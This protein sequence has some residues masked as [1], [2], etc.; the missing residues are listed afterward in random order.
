[1]ILLLQLPVAPTIL[2]F[3]AAPLQHG[4]KAFVKIRHKE[5]C[6]CLCY[7]SAPAFLPQL[8]PLR[9]PT[10]LN[11][12]NK[13]REDRHRRQT[14]IFHTYQSCSAWICGGS[15]RAA[16]ASAAG[17]SPANST[18]QRPRQH[19]GGRQSPPACASLKAYAGERAIVNWQ[20]VRR[21]RSSAWRLVVCY[22][23]RFFRH[24]Y[25]TS[26]SLCQRLRYMLTLLH[27]RAEYWPSGPSA[28]AAHG[29]RQ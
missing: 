26:L 3:E 15:V 5:S 19:T 13:L 18:A 17:D 25:L 22:H 7:S 29:V 20:D 24:F 23:F 11:I 1:M 27:N 6:K 4:D 2:S 21:F 16:V 10:E 28:L 8:S 9:V 12:C 14:P